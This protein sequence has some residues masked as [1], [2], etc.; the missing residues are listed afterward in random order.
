MTRPGS[1]ASP[2]IVPVDAAACR[3]YRDPGGVL[4]A[5]GPGV[6]TRATLRLGPPSPS[7]S[8]AGGRLKVTR[9][10]HARAKRRTL[11]PVRGGPGCHWYDSSDALHTGRGGS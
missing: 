2:R 11:V 3:A 1:P 10:A 5:G 4:S 9:L 7:L 6:E 8:E